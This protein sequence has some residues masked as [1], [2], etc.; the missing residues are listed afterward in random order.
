MS[1]REA[2][3][4]IVIGFA[5][6]AFGGSAI[7]SGLPTASLPANPAALWTGVVFVAIAIIVIGPYLRSL[8]K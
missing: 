6:G 8:P 3:R 2:W 7:G 4:R 5:T 1:E